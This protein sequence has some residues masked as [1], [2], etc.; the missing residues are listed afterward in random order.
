MSKSGK[1]QHDREKGGHDTRIHAMR[2][3]ITHDK[4][5]KHTISS[6]DSN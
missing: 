2:K 1:K 3:T 5:K 4:T 6:K